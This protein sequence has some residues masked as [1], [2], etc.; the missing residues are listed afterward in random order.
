MRTQL[1]AAFAATVLLGCNNDAVTPVENSANVS[2]SIASRSQLQK[3][4]GTHVVTVESAKVLIKNIKFHQFPS[5]DANDVKVGPY[6][7]SLSLTG[8]STTVL[9]TRVPPGMYDR[10]RFT[11][12]KP[13][14]FEPIPD[15]E[16]REG[17]SGQLRYSVIVRGTYNGAGFV[18]KS[19]ENASQEVRLDAPITVSDE[20]SVNVTMTVDPHSWFFRNG[21]ELDPTNPANAQAIDN[22]IK[23]SFARAFKDNNRDGRPD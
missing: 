14:D 10:V 12:H 23:A 11:L 4:D 21:Q 13:E 7:V 6:A 16:F 5:D 15:P 17:E 19:R 2:L 3:T 8:N 20:G 9:A 18:Y 22:A 1:A